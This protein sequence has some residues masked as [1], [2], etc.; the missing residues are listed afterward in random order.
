MRRDWPARAQHHDACSR[1]S[2]HQPLKRLARAS[3]EA[4]EEIGPE[5][6]ATQQH[7]GVQSRRCQTIDMS[8]V[9]ARRSALEYFAQADESHITQLWLLH[10]SS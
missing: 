5:Q 10:A 8:A 6:C 3:A 7:D 1:R 2:K 4:A 9:E